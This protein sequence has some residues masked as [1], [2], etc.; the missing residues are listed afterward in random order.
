MLYSN[1]DLKKLII[2]LVIEQTLAIAVGMAAVSYT[3]LP[4][5]TICNFVNKKEVT[6]KTL[7]VSYTHL[8]EP[9]RD[10]KQNKRRWFH[11]NGSWHRCNGCRCFL[12]PEAVL[13]LSV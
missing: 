6:E 7:A 8:P 12:P 3:H 13:R 9:R 2:P 4:V 10:S 11:R 1:K 5:V